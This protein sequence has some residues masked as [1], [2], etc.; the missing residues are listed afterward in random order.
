MQTVNTLRLKEIKSQ[1][2][3]SVRHYHW[4]CGQKC[5]KKEITHTHTNLYWDLLLFLTATRTTGPLCVSQSAN[6]LLISF[7][8]SLSLSLAV[9]V[10]RGA[11]QKQM[12]EKEKGGKNAECVSGGER[13]DHLLQWREIV[14]WMS[15]RKSRVTI[16]RTNRRRRNGAT[17]D[18]KAGT[19]WELPAW[20]SFPMSRQT[21]RAHSDTATHTH[22][23]SAHTLSP[24]FLIHV[25]LICASQNIVCLFTHNTW[26]VLTGTTGT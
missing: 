23:N 16:W 18:I 9:Q 6:G 4:I 22:T 7:F 1:C 17:Y 3:L 5:D 13:S 20:G 2:N 10:K 15:S 11:G 21:A 14:N 24:R 12:T 19:A 26:L 25:W 8:F